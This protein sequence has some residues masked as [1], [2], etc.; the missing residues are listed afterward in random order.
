MDLG[1]Y[2]GSCRELSLRRKLE[3]QQQATELQRAIELQRR[4]FMGLQLLD[5]KK[6]SLSSAAIASAYSLTSTATQPANPVDVSCNGTTATTTTT[7]SSDESPTEDKSKSNC[8]H[9]SLKEDG[10]AQPR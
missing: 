9:L 2:D 8:S 4:R 1:L 7:S 6:R 10:D 5:L 3:E